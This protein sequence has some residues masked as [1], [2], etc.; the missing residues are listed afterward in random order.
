MTENLWYQIVEIYKEKFH[1]NEE[2][3]NL[4]AVKDILKLSVSGLSNA[5]IANHYDFDIEYV[6]SVLKEFL[7]F[8]GWDRDVDFSPLLLYK[9]HK[10]LLDFVTEAK[11]ISA[12]ADDLLAIMCYNLCKQF[13]ELER[14]INDNYPD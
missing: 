8:T 1:T 5:T 3:I 6:Q 14:T 4:I 7:G 2:I 11:T 10:A 12:T 9:N 13:E